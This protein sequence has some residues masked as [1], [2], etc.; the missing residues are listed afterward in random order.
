MSRKTIQLIV[1]SDTHGHWLDR[2]DNLEASLLNTS[3]CIKA[4]QGKDSDISLTIDLGDFIQGSSFATYL[5]QEHKDGKV[6][7]RAMNAMG[8]DYQLIGN[9]EFN[10]G[11][12][13]RN[14]II[15]DIEAKI[16]NANI[17]DETTDQPFLGKAYDIIER[18]GIRIGI[19]GVTTSYIPNWE[20]PANY[21]GLRFND[22]F[23]SAKYYVDL[24]RPQVDLLILAYHG[25]FE[26]DLDTNEPLEEL[27]KENQ[28]SQML[29]GIEGV[30]VLLTGHQHRELN[31]LVKQ[32]YVMQPGSV[33]DLVGEVIIEMDKDKHIQAM[34]GYLHET[35]TYPADEGL[36]QLMEP[37]LTQGYEWLH[38]V[39]GTAPLLQTTTDP[40]TARV[41]GHPFIEMLNQIQLDLTGADFS[42]VALVN[43]AFVNFHGEITN[44][45]LLKSYPFYN[46]ISKVNIKGEDLYK[47]MEFNL[48]YFVL[49]EKTQT[50]QVNKDYIIPKAKHYNYD[51]YSGMIT[52]VDM[53]QAV[54]QRVKG[55]INQR[56]GQLI[57]PNESY[58]VALSQ[59][60]SVGGGNYKWYTKDKIESISDIDIASLI[61]VALKEYTAEKWDRI[62]SD[63][64]H[65]VWQPE[66][67]P[68]K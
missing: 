21:E 52:I 59:Y 17:I 63:Y 4:L 61:K 11:A 1:T 18:E 40:L 20:L 53:T 57:N 39:L 28:G 56:S 10:F 60:R 9:H 55:I 16:L 15:Q 50:M 41:E 42:A 13:Y 58:S 51:L 46:L 6:L 25:G 19:V 36:K 34:E 31:Q 43:D 48:E 38:E 62:N 33:G 35:D 14:H 37:E 26:R 32:T 44:E 29:N 47:V 30:D 7:A 8:Y 27:T 54:G 23:E 3:T 2:P 64:S 22:A 45:I 66:V 24:V 68:K 5:S 49:D 65:V 12:D 67:K